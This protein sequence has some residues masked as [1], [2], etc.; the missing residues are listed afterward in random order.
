[1]K[2]KLT[3][4]L[5]LVLVVIMA[6]SLMTGCSTSSSGKGT[7]TQ[8][9]NKVLFSY[10]GTDV[11]LKEAW[12]YA[13]MLGAQYEKTYSSYDGTDVT[14]K[15]AWLYAKMLSAQYEQTYSS[16]YGSDFW[17]MSMG[18]D[19]DGNDQTFEEYVKKQVI[20]QMKQNIILIKKADKY[21]CKLTHSEKQQCSDSALSYYQDKTGKK[22][23]K[24][25]GAT[26]EDVEKI[27]EDSTLASKV[28]KKIEGK[29]KV[30]VTDDEARKSTIYRVVF[31]TTKT[32]DN[33][34][35]TEMSKKEKKAVKAKAEK[36]LKEI[37]SGKKTIKKVA[38]EQ[39]YSNTDES[40]AAGESEEGEA[41]EKVMK[42]MKDGDIADKVLECDNGYVIAKLVAYTDKE[43]TASNKKTLKEQKQSEAFQKKYDNWTKKL[44]KKWDYDKDVDQKLWAQVSLKSADSTA[45]ETSTETTAASSEAS[46]TEASSE[47]TTAAKSK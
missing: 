6:L 30:T 31:A 47:A 20:S 26:R 24:E 36:A 12:L 29:E 27:Y 10:D 38:K 44:E 23:M 7:K 19:D 28:Q 8:D 2:A 18:K 4:V 42:S 37:Q 25:C 43:E 45:T 16:Y 14:L 33:G 9:G 34:Q 39:N 1:M 5:S 40:Y 15:E 21:D 3:K 35:T 22:V 41:F 13:K 17:S 32:G 46:T 11:T